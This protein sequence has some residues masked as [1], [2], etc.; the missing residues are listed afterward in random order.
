MSDLLTYLSQ[1]QKIE[2][3]EK[4]LIRVKKRSAEW[5]AK[6]RKLRDKEL[7]RESKNKRTNKCRAKIIE[8]KKSPKTKRNIDHIRELAKEFY[9]SESYV[10]DLWYKGK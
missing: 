10:L 4:E 9:L 2:E 8:I 5:R 6:Y 3:L 7:G 1:K